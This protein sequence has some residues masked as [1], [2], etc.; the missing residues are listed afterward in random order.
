MEILVDLKE[1]A[2]VLGVSTGTANFYVKKYNLPHFKIGK[3]TRFLPGDIDA[4]L[5]H[6]R[7]DCRQLLWTLLSEYLRTQ[8]DN[9]PKDIRDACHLLI[10]QTI[11]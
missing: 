5:K 2:K 8:K 6:M 7:G 9:I 10:E 1:V 4:F 11:K 3:H